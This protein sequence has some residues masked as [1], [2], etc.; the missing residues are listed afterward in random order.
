MC[1]RACVRSCVRP[2]VRVSTTACHAGVSAVP[3]PDR[4]HDIIRLKTLLS[5]LETVSLCLS[6]ETLKALGPF[7][8]T[9]NLLR[10]TV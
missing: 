6:G 2:C 10:I 1:V 8:T 7:Y 4:E 3:A 5:T 9:Q